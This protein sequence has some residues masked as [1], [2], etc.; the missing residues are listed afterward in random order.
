[1]AVCLNAIN[2]FSTFVM[3]HAGA[4]GDF[5]AYPHHHPPQKHLG[6]QWDLRDDRRSR[7]VKRRIE[8]EGAS[9]GSEGA[10]GAPWD[11]GAG[12]GGGQRQRAPI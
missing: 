6:A 3:E 7:N 4:R 11:A 12:R 1:M 8:G 5:Q 2:I 10:A 9:E